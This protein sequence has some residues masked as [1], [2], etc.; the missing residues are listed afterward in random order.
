M[1]GKVIKPHIHGVVVGNSISLPGLT[2]GTKFLLF[3]DSSGGTKVCVSS[4]LTSLLLAC[5]LDR[6]LDGE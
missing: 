3:F 4:R 1:K 5:R 6:V 2:V